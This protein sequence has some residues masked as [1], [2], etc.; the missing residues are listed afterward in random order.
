VF[1]A[2]FD[3]GNERLRYASAGHPPALLVPAAGPAQLLGGALG[4]PLGLP[5]A[6]YEAE[7]Q[8]FPSGAALVAYTDGLIE[9]R[10]QVIDDRLADLVTAA[11]SCA[12]TGPDDLCDRLVFELL[13]GRDLFDDA[14]LLVAARL[15]TTS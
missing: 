13:A 1:V 7:D 8:A 5:G 2:L 14:A 12:G 11:S 4:P 9:R 15:P 6:R 3:P 10:D